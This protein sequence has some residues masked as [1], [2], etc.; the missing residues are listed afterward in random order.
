MINFG[1]SS[2]LI[3][4]VSFDTDIFAFLKQNDYW[5]LFLFSFF[6]PLGVVH[7]LVKV[8]KERKIFKNSKQ[9]TE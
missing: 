6:N 1:G 5:N 4:N 7:I 8:T 9:N 2:S 3:M